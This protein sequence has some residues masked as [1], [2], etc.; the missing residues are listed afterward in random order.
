[1]NKI[2][3]LDND[4]LSIQYLAKKD[5]RLAKLF[6]M[7]GPLT[8]QVADDPYQF[9]VE[10]IIG[11]MLSN[12]VADV[13]ASRLSTLCHGSINLNTINKLNDQQIRSIGISNSKVS[14][15]RNLTVAIEN[16]DLNLASFEMLT[17]SDV[18]KQ[19]TSVRG[20]GNWTA[21][22][23]LIFVLD[24][25]DILPYEDMAFI[26][27]YQWLSKANNIDSK[28]L[29]LKCQKWKPYTT[30]AARYLYQAINQGLTKNEFH[31]FKD[32]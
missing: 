13:L 6:S 23:Y 19:L 20:I 14:Y 28:T 17:D 22:M 9:L 5:K 29:T 10:A 32:Y 26:Q 2:I 16:S 4:C 7:I 8:Y 24:R 25:Q 30:I 1:M 12:K 3:A 27:A 21:K 15:I 31:L 11:Q 18:L